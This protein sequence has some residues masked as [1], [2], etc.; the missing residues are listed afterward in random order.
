VHCWGGVG[1]A[2]T[3]AAACLVA[4]GT[5]PEDAMAIVR[6]TRGRAIESAAQERFVCEFGGDVE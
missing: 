1:R 3:I 2:G 5:P 4:R 6:K